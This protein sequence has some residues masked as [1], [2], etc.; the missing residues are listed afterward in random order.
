MLLNSA[1]TGLIFW[2]I[3]DVYGAWAGLA[4][5]ACLL[6]MP[7]L[8]FHDHL[9]SLDAAASSMIVGTLVLFWKT[10]QRSQGWVDVTLGLVWGL[11]VGTKINAVFVW[12]TLLL[13][14]L[15]F[16]RRPRMLARLGVMGAAAVIVFAG[17]WPWLYHDT[18][19]R[20]LDYVR[21][22]TVDHWKIGQWYL[23][24]FWMPPP[25]HFPFVLSAVV[26]PPAI[27]ACLFL[28]VGRSLARREERPLGGFL[29]LN[30]LAPMLALA[31]GQSM[32]YD[33]DRL[34]MP[35]MPFIA[36][37]AGIGLHTAA[38]AVTSW[39]GDLGQRRAVRALAG[40]VLAALVLLPSIV[41]AAQLYPHLLSYYSGLVGGVS[42]ATRRGFETTYWC[43]TYNETL[44]TLNALAQPGDVVWID[45]WSHNVMIYYQLS[46]RLRDDLR[47]TGPG[48]IASLWD[49]EIVTVEREFYEADW[50]VFHH[51][52]TFFGE[53]G[54]RHP[55]VRWMALREPEYELRYGGVPLVSVYRKSVA[56]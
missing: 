51:R 56:Y 15:A 34:F 21:W 5:S 8:F 25:W 33:N 2:L 13:W 44:D 16:D 49:P 54:L 10:R 7:R 17:A 4:A 1:A 42:G 9:A 18:L 3:A 47:W 48:E 45:P 32:V 28:G 24:R 6:A 40:G 50:V 52:Q 46:G 43:E 55:L 27:L 14:A 26:V 22:I 39:L 37:L 31:I 11:A 41:A 23:G 36:A 38:Q 20:A 53:Q 30:A 29:L 12:P 19:A 35:A